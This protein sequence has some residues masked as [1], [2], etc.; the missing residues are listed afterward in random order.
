MTINYP[1][2]AA[3]LPALEFTWQ[4]SSGNVIDFSSPDWNFVM[5]VG[6][7]PN[8]AVLTKTD[9]I[10]GYAAS[11]NLIV[12]WDPGDL[13]NLTPGTWYLQV[14]ATYSPSSQQRV[15]TGSIRIDQPTLV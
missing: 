2:P 5:K 12:Q 1:T 9:G 10:T 13:K 15:L 14:T 3:S 6:R 8:P 11:P 7:F 4:D